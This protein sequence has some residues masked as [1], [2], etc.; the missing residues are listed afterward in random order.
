MNKAKTGY[1]AGRRRVLAQL[2]SSTMLVAVLP[3][4][5][6]LAQGLGT[7]DKPVE[8]RI[9]ANDA[10][11]NLWQEQLVPLFNQPVFLELVG[12][13]GDAYAPYA[14]HEGQQARLIMHLNRPLHHASLLYKARAPSGHHAFHHN[15][16]AA[17]GE[18]HFAGRRPA[19]GARH[20]QNARSDAKMPSTRMTVRRLTRTGSRAIIGWTC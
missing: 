13:H 1:F 2:L 4:T 15:A 19:A 9:M 17:A 5:G 20:A 10:Y 11:A 6:A 14:Q 8:V 16:S 18:D 7:A 3:V 12:G